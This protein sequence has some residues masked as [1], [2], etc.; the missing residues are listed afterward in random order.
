MG[1]YIQYLEAHVSQLSTRVL[2]HEYLSVI[3]MF[4]YYMFSK[5]Q[6]PAIN[7]INV[8]IEDNEQQSIAIQDFNKH[9]FI[10]LCIPFQ[11]F[12]TLDKYD[13]RELLATQLLEALV[14]FAETYEVDK[15]HFIDC[16]NKLKQKG[17]IFANE[18]ITT[19]NRGREVRLV[20][21]CDASYN[22]YLVDVSNRRRIR[23]FEI[24]LGTKDLLRYYIKRI[25]WASDN[26]L[27]IYQANNRDYW[28]YDIDTGIVQFHYPRAESGDPKAQ[29]D[30]ALKYKNGHG[31]LASKEAAIYWLQQSAA[32]GYA[33][34]IKALA[35]TDKMP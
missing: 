17:F 10:R 1:K 2:K 19:R 3:N 11:A 20:F 29:Y 8:T 30:L 18:L 23:F 9:A 12:E 25:Q 21:E 31:V 6:C 14:L 28:S 34:A 35:Q 7:K 32:Q 27:L 4:D 26:E 15:A 13:A 33:R 5:I 22:I 24:G 16:F